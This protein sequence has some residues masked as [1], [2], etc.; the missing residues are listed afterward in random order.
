MWAVVVL[1]LAFV[2]G[3][4]TFASHHRSAPRAIACAAED[5]A[6]PVDTLTDLVSYADQVSLAT[7]TRERPLPPGPEEESGGY[8]GRVVTV[9]V[10]DTV[11]RGQASKEVPRTFEFVTWGWSGSYDD[12]IAGC[13]GARLEVGRT[14]LLPLAR[15]DDGWWA[16]GDTSTN[17]RLEGGIVDG[18]DFVGDEPSAVLR[19]LDGMTVGEVA[20]V[21]AETTPDP[22]AAKYAELGA[23]ERWQAVA[24]ERG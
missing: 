9:Q 14:Y 2:L 16:F 3:V 23:I 15:D 6:Y 19:A 11:W 13:G 4:W 8:Y 22:V 21:L 10:D 12:P 18:H 5:P 1:P 7:V 20:A 17:L 24:R